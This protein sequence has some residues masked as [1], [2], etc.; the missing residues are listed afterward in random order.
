MRALLPCCKSVV[1]KV[2]AFSNFDGTFLTVVAALHESVA[3]LFACSWLKVAIAS[4]YMYNVEAHGMCA[5]TRVL[6]QTCLSAN[7]CLQMFVQKSLS[8]V[9][10][11]LLVEQEL[12]LEAF[13]YLSQTP[14]ES[15]I[16]MHSMQPAS[17]ARFS[18]RTLP[19]SSS[20]A[21]LDLAGEICS[22]TMADD[23]M[24][25]SPGIP[26]GEIVP[27]NPQKM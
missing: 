16:L 5:L 3:C 26:L 19:E 22:F 18:P 15:A 9:K 10:S 14:E 1:S 8:T 2:Q 21:S 13:M 24:S 4:N 20:W 6:S 23:A 11:V 27:P 25:V 12:L 7:V 17:Q